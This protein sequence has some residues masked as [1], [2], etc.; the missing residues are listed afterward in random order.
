[1]NPPL[2]SASA[3]NKATYDVQKPGTALTPDNFDQKTPSDPDLQSIIEAWP[4]LPE[5]LRAAVLAIV[6][7]SG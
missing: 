5:P 2:D 4:S 7:T 3:E 6:R 1:M